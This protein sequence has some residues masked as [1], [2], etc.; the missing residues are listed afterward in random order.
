MRGP[1]PLPYS[2]TRTASSLY[3]GYSRQMCYVDPWEN[4]TV[5]FSRMVDPSN[6]TRKPYCTVALVMRT[7][8]RQRYEYEYHGTSTIVLHHNM[9]GQQPT[10]RRYGPGIPPC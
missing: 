3:C 6:P 2:C 9:Q 5:E 1:L 4:S 8:R 10:E 7:R